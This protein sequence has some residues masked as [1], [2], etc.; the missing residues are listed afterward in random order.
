MPVKAV[1][2]V[3][4]LHDPQRPSGPIKGH[5]IDNQRLA[6]DELDFHAG[7]EGKEARARREKVEV[8]S[9]SP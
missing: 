7:A 2:I 4:H 5:R 3:P 8:G 9:H 1:G 6:G